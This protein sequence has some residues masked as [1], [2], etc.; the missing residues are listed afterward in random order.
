M[1]Q[2]ECGREQLDVGVMAHIFIP[3]DKRIAKERHA[4]ACMFC[5]RVVA[6]EPNDVCGKQLGGTGLESHAF[7]CL[8]HIADV[9]TRFG[10]DD[11]LDAVLDVDQARRFVREW[12]DARVAEREAREAV[13]NPDL[14]EIRKEPRGLND[15]HD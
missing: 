3:S 5:R 6:D 15:P 14:K 8:A 13:F 9:R 12:P 7:P 10:I 1:G 11:L 4:H 2:R